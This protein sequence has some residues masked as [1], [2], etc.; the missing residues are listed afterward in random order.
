MNVFVE[1][2][3]PDI[4]LAL[5]VIAAI[6][7]IA[8]RLTWIGTSNDRYTEQIDEMLS[9]PSNCWSIMCSY[10]GKSL[11]GDIA[12]SQWAVLIIALC[13][14]LVWS[15]YRASLTSVLAARITRL[16][17]ES[18]DGL[19]SSDYQMMLMGGGSIEEVFR[20]SPNE[21]VHGKMFTK[22]FREPQQVIVQR[23]SHTL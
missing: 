13:G 21:S 18:L 1:P 5:V 23:H 3:S 20:S 12:K 6:A 4:W 2:F 15:A 8:F 14:V 19:L 22:Y 11:P 9:I 7:A 10:L 16:P 17:F